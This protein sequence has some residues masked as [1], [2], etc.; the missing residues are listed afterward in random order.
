MGIFTRAGRG[1]MAAENDRDLIRPGEAGRGP[2]ADRRAPAAAPPRPARRSRGH[3]RLRRCLL[4]PGQKRLDLTQPDKA[5]VPCL[6]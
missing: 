2:G 3:R 1:T 6:A 5:P 4:V